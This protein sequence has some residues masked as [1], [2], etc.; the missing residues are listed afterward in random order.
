M[1]ER[2]SKSIEIENGDTV[3]IA[4]VLEL[5]KLQEVKREKGKVLEEGSL[6]PNG[7]DSREV[8]EVGN[9]ND[10]ESD[11]AEMTGENVESN[12]NPLTV[13]LVRR[14]IKLEDGI[15]RGLIKK[16]FLMKRRMISRKI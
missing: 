9:N 1:A 5:P 6:N 10:I 16:V 14:A 12:Q 11:M 7:V 3:K 2:L 4:D 15:D 13:N 8:L